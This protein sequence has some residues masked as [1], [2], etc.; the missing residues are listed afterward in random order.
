MRLITAM[1]LCGFIV[2]G[3]RRPPAVRRDH[4]IR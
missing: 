2:R 1:N 3:A 4:R